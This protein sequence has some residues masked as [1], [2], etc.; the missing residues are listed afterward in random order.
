[1]SSRYSNQGQLKNQGNKKVFPKT[2]MKFVPKVEPNS[3]QTLSNSIRDSNSRQSD[4]TYSVGAGAGDGAMFSSRIKMGEN[5]EWVSNSGILSGNFVNYLPQDE[6]VASGL[7]AHEGGLDPLESQRVVDL[8]NRE[9]SRL[10][11]LKPR[12]FWKEGYFFCFLFN[13]MI[14]FS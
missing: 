13:L 4:T 1:M 6:A 8:L 5:G 9:L 11:K 3:K 2:Q 10:L 12:D 7:G 14:F